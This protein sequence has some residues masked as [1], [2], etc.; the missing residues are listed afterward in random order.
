[1]E[2]ITYLVSRKILANEAIGIA[3]AQR[4]PPNHGLVALQQPQQ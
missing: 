2:Y 4:D 1:M 3:Q